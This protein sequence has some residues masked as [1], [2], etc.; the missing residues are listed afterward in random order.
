MAFF[1]ALTYC[2]SM[3]RILSILSLIYLAVSTSM[4]YG[5]GCEGFGF[6]EAPPR[7]I[8]FDQSNIW[9]VTG[10]DG[11]SGIILG[12]IHTTESRVVNRYSKLTALVEASDLYFSEVNFETSAVEKLV[13]AGEGPNS[14]KQ[15][16][17]DVYEKL[18]RIAER[19]RTSIENLVSKRDWYLW[20]DLSRPLEFGYGIDHILWGQRKASGKRIVPLEE[21]DHLIAALD[22]FKDSPTVL[23]DIVCDYETLE[24]QFTELKKLFIEG[25]IPAFHRESQRLESRTADI[26]KRF[27][28]ELL[29]ARNVHMIKTLSESLAAGQNFFMTVG[30]AHLPG[31]GGL[32]DLLKQSGFTAEPLTLEQANQMADPVRRQAL[33]KKSKTILKLAEWMKDN[34]TTLTI[35]PS[36]LPKFQ[37]VTMNEMGDLACQG[38]PCDLKSYYSAQTVYINDSQYMAFLNENPAVLGNLAASLLHYYQELSLGEEALCSRWQDL[39]MEAYLLQNQYLM[40]HQTTIARRGY[41]PPPGRCR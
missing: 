41:S 14:L 19:R 32:L 8:A 7:P 35:E 3:G 1:A 25:D 33:E 13:A 9:K 30:L 16:P 2:P 21:M 26:A 38:Q 24:A 18:R 36:R 5:N 4:A 40:T 29:L 20:S 17:D 10:P 11:R 27:H 15:M 23:K 37:W 22:G 6:K 28:D 34:V 39:D 31:E 12:I